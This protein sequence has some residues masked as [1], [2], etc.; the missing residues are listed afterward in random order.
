MKETF[1][2]QYD[3]AKFT[4]KNGEGIAIASELG[5]E[6]GDV[7]YDQIYD[8]TIIAGLNIKSPKTGVVKRFAL[9]DVTSYNGSVVK[10]I[11]ESLDTPELIVTIYND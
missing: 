9:V 2:K 10:W 3:A 6:A 4:W 7:P 5:I 11:F 8:E 1:A